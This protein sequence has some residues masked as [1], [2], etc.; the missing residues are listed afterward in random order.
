M[1]SLKT[2][3]KAKFVTRVLQ[4]GSEPLYD[5]VL[6]VDALAQQVLSAKTT[7][8]AF[9]EIQVTISEMAVRGS[10]VFLAWISAH[11]AYDSTATRRMAMRRL[12]SRPSTLLTPICCL[13]SLQRRPPVGEL[14]LTPEYDT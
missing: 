13:I 11:V 2:N 12:F 3:P 8:K 5:S 6:D 14:I 9:S 10:I 4:F 7:L 1:T